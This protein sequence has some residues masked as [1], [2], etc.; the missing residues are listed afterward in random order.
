MKNMHITLSKDWLDRLDEL[1]ARLEQSRTAL[2]REAVVE[3]VL[4]REREM[5]EEE[6]GR[7]AE[8][9]GPASNEFTHW[10]EAEV[11]RLLHEH[12]EW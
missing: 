9:M 5:I 6:M 8:E 12:T 2:V 3:Y 1:S 7:Y 4:K 11:D 10:T